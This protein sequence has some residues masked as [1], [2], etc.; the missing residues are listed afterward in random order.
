MWLV[1]AILAAVFWGLHY[2]IAEKLFQ[3]VYPV[4]ILAIEMLFGSLLFF[5][6]A[7]FSHLKI[8][9][10]TMLTQPHVLRLVITEILVLVMASF[11]I[12]ISI[13]SKNATVAAFVEVMYP[14]FTMGFTW[15]IF[16][17]HHLNASVLVGGAFISVGVFIISFA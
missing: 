2:S 7:Y 14:L 10:H 13:E 3:H 5:I 16:H 4:T 17:E 12:V 6:V 1:Y 9:V 8:D 11:F 15:L